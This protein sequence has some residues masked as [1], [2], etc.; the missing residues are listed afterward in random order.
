M[1]LVSFQCVTRATAPIIIG[2]MAIIKQP[3]AATYDSIFA[4]CTDLVEST[5]WKYTCHGTP[6]KISSRP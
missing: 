4:F 5:R 6:P 1:N 3:N 2:G